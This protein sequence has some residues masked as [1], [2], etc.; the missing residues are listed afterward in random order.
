MPHPPAP[1]RVLGTSTTLRCE[2]GQTDRGACR[3]TSPAPRRPANRDRCLAGPPARL[4][5]CRPAERARSGGRD[6]VLTAEVRAENRTML[7]LLPGLGPHG[8]RTGRPGDRRP[9]EPGEPSRQAHPDLHCL[10]TAAAR[11]DRTTWKPLAVVDDAQ[12]VDRLVYQ[13]LL[14]GQRPLPLAVHQ[15]RGAARIACACPPPPACPCGSA[16]PT[17][18]SWRCQESSRCAPLPGDAG[19]LTQVV[20]KNIRDRHRMTGRSAPSTASP[21]VAPPSP[22]TRSSPAGRTP[23]SASPPAPAA[24]PNDPS[25]NSRRSVYS[26]RQW[27]DSHQFFSIASR[28]GGLAMSSGTPMPGES[29]PAPAG[30]HKAPETESNWRR[31]ERL[32]RYQRR[33]R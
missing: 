24:D 14:H 21:A 15:R 11:H 1:V 30:V 10:L 3:R 12:L 9:Q 19:I 8:D 7:V 25:P 2:K 26:L 13:G 5:A 20:A 28:P 17:L 16:R 23:C 22:W 29:G 33:D 31:R 27:R 18:L 4:R 6:R 32:A